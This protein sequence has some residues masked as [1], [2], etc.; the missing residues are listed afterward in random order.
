MVE[1]AMA[2]FIYYGGFLLAVVCG[3]FAIRKA[4]KP[5]TRILLLIAAAILV[6]AQIALWQVIVSTG[7]GI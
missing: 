6:L 5:K 3:C 2:I 7:N 1:I 4:I